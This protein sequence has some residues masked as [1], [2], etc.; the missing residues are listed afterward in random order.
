MYKCIIRTDGS[1][2]NSS[3]KYSNTMTK[4]KMSFHSIIANIHALI[5]VCSLEVST[6]EEHVRILANMPFSLS[7]RGAS[8]L[9]VGQ[10][11]KR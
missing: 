1:I 2:Q 9:T 10:N 11:D 5:K 7:H 3:K 4:D 8:T 6:K